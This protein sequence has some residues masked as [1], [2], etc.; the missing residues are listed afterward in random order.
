MKGRPLCRP[1][2]PNKSPLPSSP[3]SRRRAAAAACH[4]DPG[5]RPPGSWSQS[6]ASPDC[7]RPSGPGSLWT[8]L[9]PAGRVHRPG[10]AGVPVY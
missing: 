1:W 7:P 10:F 2:L 6:A 8:S 4:G 3:P 9:A 5:P